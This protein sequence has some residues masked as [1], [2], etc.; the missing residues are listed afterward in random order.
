[1]EVVS[2]GPASEPLRAAVPHRSAIRG[3]QPRLPAQQEA[4]PSAVKLTEL[5]SLRGKLRVHA[6]G[7]A[8]MLTEA[9]TQTAEQPA[10][11]PG[12]GA[13]HRGLPT[14][15]AA[16]GGADGQS[17]RIPATAVAGLSGVF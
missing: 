11:E 4:R 16:C 15:R 14:P 2:P 17:R 8:R 5:E 9:G 7:M 10:G 6:E 12:A 3:R 1:M 13:S